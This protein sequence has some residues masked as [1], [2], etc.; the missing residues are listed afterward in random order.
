M[1]ARLT[2]GIKATFWLLDREYRGLSL[3]GIIARACPPVECDV[4]DYAATIGTWAAEHQE[5]LEAAVPPRPATPVSGAAGI[6]A[7]LLL[8][9]WAWVRARKRRTLC[10]NSHCP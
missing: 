4:E 1:Y 9:A 8:A 7:L 3:Q 5:T 2:D 10:P 6:L